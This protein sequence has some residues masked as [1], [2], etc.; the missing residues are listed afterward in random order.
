MSTKKKIS[1]GVKEL[2]RDLGEISVARLLASYRETEGLSQKDFAKILG[3]T[4]ASLCDLEKGRKIPSVTRA[5]KIA[6]KLGDMEIFWVET[7]IQDQLRK[8]KLR[9]EVT[10]REVS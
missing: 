3:M 1:Y 7:A 4:S 2:R 8:E 10:L 9:F 5:A 6:K